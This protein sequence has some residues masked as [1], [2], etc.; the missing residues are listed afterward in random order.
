[1]DL[2]R[3]PVVRDAAPADVAEVVRVAG[4]VGQDQEWAGGD[5]H[6]LQHLMA[7][8]RLVVA[9]QGPRLV[10]YGATRTLD[11]PTGPISMLADLFVSPD[12][13]GAGLGRAMLERLWAYDTDRMTFSSTHPSALPLYAGFGLAAWWP[14]LYLSGDPSAMPRSSG[15]TV[16]KSSPDEAASLEQS[17]VGLERSADYSAWSARPG[18]GAFVVRRDGRPLATSVV[19]GKRATLEH[20]RM[21]PGLDDAEAIAVVAAAV[22]QVDGPVAAYLP[23]PHPAVRVLLAAGWRI[24][25][26]DLFM[27]TRPD[28][29]DPC[30]DVPSPALG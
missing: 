9:E 19:A 23:A 29:L 4:K 22:S 16:A 2:K 18:G 5:E 14:L 26:Y 21:A 12:A 6:Y 24:E 20:L 13:R 7:T 30:R 15:L 3:E 25:E 8:G 27:A 17:W 11:S 28:L 1:V 10:G